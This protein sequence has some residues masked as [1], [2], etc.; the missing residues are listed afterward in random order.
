MHRISSRAGGVDADSKVVASVALEDAAGYLAGA[1]S[2]VSR[3][4]GIRSSRAMAPVTAPVIVQS[5]GMKDSVRAT[6]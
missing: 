3:L 5:V 4:V 2:S 6:C 1:V